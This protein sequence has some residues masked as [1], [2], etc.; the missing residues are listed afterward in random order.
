MKNP[1]AYSQHPCL[2][3]GFSLL[4]ITLV[5]ALLG[6]LLALSV[7]AYQQYVHRA[8]RV[9]A[10]NQLL[11]AASCQERIF[12]RKGSYDTRR[13]ADQIKNDHY[14][15]RFTPQDLDNA[16]TFTVSA[17]EKSEHAV[18]DCGQLSLDHSGT[19]GISGD[20]SLLGKCWEGR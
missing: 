11:S 13:C 17:R 8:W 5:V 12:T 15:I 20:S 19:R 14:L 4:E 6:I 16:E 9:D 18:D 3:D 1:A 7:P 10:I 2:P